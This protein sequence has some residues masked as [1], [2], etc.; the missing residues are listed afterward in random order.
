M[1]LDERDAQRELEKERQLEATRAKFAGFS[2]Q[3][4]GARAV[5]PIKTGLI[6][7][8]IFWCAVMGLLFAVMTHYL[9]PRQ[10]QVLANG[11]LVIERASDG[12]FY[13]LGSVNGRE[14]KFLF[15]TGASLVTVS[16]A[17][18]QKAAL[19][20]GAS[21]TFQTANGTMRGRIVQGV[22]V[23]L[24]PLGVSPIQV[25][26]GLDSGGDFDALLGQS[27]LSKFDITLREKQLV[28][29]AR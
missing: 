17:F 21:T 12:H 6:P 3:H 19:T 8:L 25:A 22:S 1:G 26:V 29:R 9:K 27:F 24:G 18:A 20:G 10:A 13:A 16:E 14:A 11:D 7:M 4:L 5:S 23:V 28:L 2:R 15:D